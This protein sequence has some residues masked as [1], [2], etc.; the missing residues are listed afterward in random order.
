MEE[1]KRI[2]NF[3]FRVLGQGDLV[4][5]LVLVISGVIIW[6]IRLINILTMSL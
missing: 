5:R 3:G 1:R 6:L 4:N 2:H